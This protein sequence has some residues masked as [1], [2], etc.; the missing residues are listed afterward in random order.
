MKSIF[1]FSLVLL[2]FI[3]STYMLQQLFLPADPIMNYQLRTQPFYLKFDLPGLDDLSE[4]K[5]TDTFEALTITLLKFKD[6]FV[7]YTKALFITQID[8]LKVN[9]N[10]IKLLSIHPFPNSADFEIDTP[11][12]PC[13]VKF[14]KG[15][16]QSLSKNTAHFISLVNSLKN[17][18]TKALDIQ[19]SLFSLY[20]ET[21]E[22]LN[23][24][25]LLTQFSLTINIYPRE[26]NNFHRLL[27]GHCSGL[28]DPHNETFVATQHSKCYKD[29]SNDLICSGYFVIAHSPEIVFK[30]VSIPHH[31]LMVNLTSTYI[32]DHKVVRLSCEMEKDYFLYN[33]SQ[34]DEFQQCVK[35]INEDLL[36]NINKFCQ[37]VPT[38]NK[39]DPITLLNSTLIL[40]ENQVNSLPTKY[41]NLDLP[42]PPFLLSHVQPIDMGQLYP[43][44][45]LLNDTVYKLKDYALVQSD[46]VLDHIEN[47]LVEYLELTSMVAVFIVSMV[48][49]LVYHK[50]SQCK[51]S[52]KSFDVYVR[53]YLP[54]KSPRRR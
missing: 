47:F 15:A 38:P 30:A 49:L 52:P 1:N 29:K 41:K 35:A 12:A 22:I 33:C 42:P 25:S 51:G 32:K 9:L 34:N 48:F 5:F 26:F 28:I 11:V 53:D 46:H 18:S 21:L 8:E 16:Y 45:S 2:L 14:I 36:E 39:M 20:L 27:R 13:H 19:T 37:I 10:T 4:A 3:Q 23:R 50:L 24:L 31:S 43:G 44:R 54:I 7:D 40:S 6:D 17:S